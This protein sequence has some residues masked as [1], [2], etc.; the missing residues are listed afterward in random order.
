MFE[1]FVNPITGDKGTFDSVGDFAVVVLN[2]ALGIAMSISLIGIISSGIKFVTSRGDAKA[3]MSAKTALTF[4]IVA[5][6]LSLGAY[7]IV[8]LVR[9]TLTQSSTSIQTQLNSIDN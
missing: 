9:G 1:N 3:T 8:G 4:S 5:L 2:T 7:A 6:V